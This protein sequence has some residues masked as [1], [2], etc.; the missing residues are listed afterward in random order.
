LVGI[1]KTYISSLPAL[2]TGKEDYYVLYFQNVLLADVFSEIGIPILRSL[3]LSKLK[4]FICD[5]NK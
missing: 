4:A 5:E 1:T 3:L 2:A